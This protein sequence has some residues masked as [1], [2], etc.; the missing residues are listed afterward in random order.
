MQLF[1]R[2]IATGDAGGLA[3]VRTT[4]GRRVARP[5]AAAVRS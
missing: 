5:S 4:P 2:W 1:E 3:R